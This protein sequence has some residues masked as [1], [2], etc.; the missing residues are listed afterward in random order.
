MSKLVCI[1][2][3][4]QSDHWSER[5]SYGGLLASRPW[6]LP[7]PY[8]WCGGSRESLL[9]AFAGDSL[10]TRSFHDEIWFIP[11]SSSWSD[12]SKSKPWESK[13]SNLSGQLDIYV[14]VY[15]DLP[16]Y[17]KPFQSFR[18][19]RRIPYKNG[20][21][22]GSVIDLDQD[23][24]ETSIQQYRDGKEHGIYC[25]FNSDGSFSHLVSYRN[26]VMDGPRISCWTNGILSSTDIYSRDER[27][28]LARDW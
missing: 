25:F 3:W 15:A 8:G 10:H 27:N 19:E 12:L 24:R 1:N 18:L 21:I 23:G 7:H 20:L 13:I 6:S 2:S 26:G 22:H 11:G 4:Q 28:G 17:R 5:N 9:S 16:W 14:P